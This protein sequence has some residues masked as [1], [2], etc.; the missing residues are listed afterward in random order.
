M[1]GHQTG[2]YLLL[3]GLERSTREMSG[4]DRVRMK[5]GMDGSKEHCARIP[6]SQIRHL[7]FDL[8]EL[9]GRCLVSAF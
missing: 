8:R 3:L 5:R 1:S 7:S 6:S 9:G 4:S 2:K